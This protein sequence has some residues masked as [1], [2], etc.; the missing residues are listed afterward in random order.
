MHEWQDLFHVRWDRKY[1]VVIVPK[2]RREVS[3]GRL[4]QRIGD[5]HSGRR[6]TVSARWAWMRA[7]CGST[8]ASR[9]NWSDAR[10][11]STSGNR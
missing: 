1:H 2:Y 9:G 10:A 5:I 6:G 11:S 4:R 8:S 7:E 3:C